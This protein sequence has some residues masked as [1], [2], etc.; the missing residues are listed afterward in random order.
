MNFKYHKNFCNK[1]QKNV[2]CEY[3]IIGRGSKSS[4]VHY[5]QYCFSIGL[6]NCKT[7]KPIIGY[8]KRY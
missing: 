1:N 2:K 3:C 5:Y 8:P 7:N 4:M 6:C